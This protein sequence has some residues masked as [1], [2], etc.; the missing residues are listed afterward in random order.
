MVIIFQYE[1]PYGHSRVSANDKTFISNTRLPF[2]AL[3][4]G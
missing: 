1:L 4:A 3:H 2:N